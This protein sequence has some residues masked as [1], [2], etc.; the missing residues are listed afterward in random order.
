MHPKAGG[1]RGAVGN[2]GPRREEEGWSCSDS[3]LNTWRE[4]RGREAAGRG[5]GSG[6]RGAIAAQA[7]GR[8]HQL[9]DAIS[10]WG[11]AL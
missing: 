6:N 2:P 4:L 10:G 9:T 11:L 8:L 1:E 5:C 7:A 3:E